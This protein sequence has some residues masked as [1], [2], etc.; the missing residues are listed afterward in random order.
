M[1]NCTQHN[2]S[3]FKCA[4]VMRMSLYITS[5]SASKLGKHTWH[6]SVKELLHAKW[7]TLT[8]SV[9][10]FYGTLIKSASHVH[11]NGEVCVEKKLCVKGVLFS[12]FLEEVRFNK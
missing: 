4:N 1:I 10:L 6:V 2:P 11:L 3:E 8:S 9:Q 12:A 5:Q 7:V